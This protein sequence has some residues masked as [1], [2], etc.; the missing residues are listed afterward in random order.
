[1]QTLLSLK[2]IYRDLSR[3]S[4]N[5]KRTYLVLLFEDMIKGISVDYVF[6]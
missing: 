1:M 5:I 3:I 6:V 4:I 2:Q